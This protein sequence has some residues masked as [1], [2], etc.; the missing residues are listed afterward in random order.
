M[1]TTNMQD[2]FNLNVS[3]AAPLTVTFATPFAKKAPSLVYLHAVL[4]ADYTDPTGMFNL[5]TGSWLKAVASGITKTSC[6]VTVKT[7]DGKEVP[8]ARVHL[9]CAA[10]E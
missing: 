3:V 6:S 5:P 8:G 9:T 1:P 4:A 7:I 2:L 10:F